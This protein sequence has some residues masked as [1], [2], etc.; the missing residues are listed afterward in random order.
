MGHETDFTIADFVAD[1]RAPTPS[2]AAELAVPLLSDLT[3]R[4]ETA[5]ERLTSVVQQQL[6]GGIAAL[7]NYQTRLRS[8]QWAIQQNMQR[9]DEL[10]G[11][12]S[13][14]IHNQLQQAA[15]KQKSQF[16]QLLHFSPLPGIERSQIRVR[17][18]EH[19]LLSKSSQTLE[20]NRN[21]LQELTHLL[22]SAS[23]LSIMDRGY[24]IVKDAENRPITSVKT[25]KVNSSFSVL[26]PDGS[27]KG[28]VETIVPSQRGSKRKT[29]P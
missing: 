13:Y 21:R 7:H 26:V 6:Q 24:A 27:I 5:R 1:L 19:R 8:P 28:R 22:N 10:N 20:R 16:Q 4:V 14:L 11:R 15:S 9:V 17:D 25:V 12:L 3:D 23:P 29:E 2:A 18:L